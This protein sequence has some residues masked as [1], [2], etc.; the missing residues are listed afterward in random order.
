MVGLTP[1]SVVT[2]H[3]YRRYHA[4]YKRRERIVTNKEITME[5]M[6]NHLLAEARRLAEI[7]ESQ[8]QNGDR[9]DPSAIALTSIA[10]SV[11]ALA[12]MNKWQKS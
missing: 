10:Y 9:P 12:E 3:P 5:D 7:A 8:A 2:K 11:L 6:L 1:D 4:P